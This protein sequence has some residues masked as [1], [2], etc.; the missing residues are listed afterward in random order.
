MIS[1][2]SVRKKYDN[3]NDIKFKDYT[4]EPG[5][6]YCILGPSGS[7][8]ST[9]LN[10]IGG[11][12]SPTEGIININGTC[13]NCLS[14]KELDRYCFQNIGFIPQELK[15]FAEFTVEDNLRILEVEGK[16][17]FSIDEVLSW[18]EMMDKR[19]SKI[20]NLSGGEKQRVA[21]ARALIKSPKVM[22]CDEPTASLNTAKGIQ[23]IEL[24]TKL[25]KEQD[26]TLLVVTHD[27]RLTG[28]FDN[29]LN[30]RDL[31]GGGHYV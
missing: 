1:I 18:V 21:I 2:K 10:L 29:T 23:I 13:L 31:L 8:K 15:L 11:L 7:G 6:S 28:Y 30:I 17:A 12:I 19:K 5:K 24:I 22:L 3:D 14:P 20:K 27:D 16:L 4:F 26:N 25:H 9:L